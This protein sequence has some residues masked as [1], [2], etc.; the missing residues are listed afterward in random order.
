MPRIIDELA[1]R[2]LRHLRRWQALSLIALG[3]LL[4]AMGSAGNPVLQPVQ[5]AEAWEPRLLRLDAPVASR[6]PCAAAGA[7]LRMS[8]EL[9]LR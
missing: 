9:S 6:E 4:G 2:R 1:L 5:T 3:I 8:C 7:R